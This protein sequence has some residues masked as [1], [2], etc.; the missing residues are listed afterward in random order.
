MTR[1]RKSKRFKKTPIEKKEDEFLRDTRSSNG[2]T[3]MCSEG[4][5]APNI[6]RKFERHVSKKSG[7]ILK[8]SI[9]EMADL[10]YDR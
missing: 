2:A 5:R 1:K 9:R 8:L 7:P 3:G 4:F 6:N 10:L